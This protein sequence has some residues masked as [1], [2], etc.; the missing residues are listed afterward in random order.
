MGLVLGLPV[1]QAH[2]VSFKGGW[3]FM[4]F[5]QA[6]MLDWQL[7]YT[8]HPKLSLG[9]D[10]VRDT[11]EPQER[12]FLIP[13][14]SWL[15]QRWNATDSQ[16][17]IYVYG[18]VGAARKGDLTEPAVE[19]AV[20]SDYETRS[21]YFSGKAQVIAAKNFNTLAIYQLRAGFAPYVGESNE[22]HSW[23]LA[24]A[25]YL[26]FAPDQTVKVG[27]VLRMF[28]K[29]VLWELGVTTKGNWNFNFMVH[30]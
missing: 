7:L 1:A 19:A 4:A 25:Q 28:Y 26:P 20:E 21:V 6:D 27:P 8:F 18:G 5:N 3:S 9:V 13:R 30:W 22:L 23:L 17:N 11:M 14:M 15:V 29:N 12:L 24:Q 2:P 16:A 10:F